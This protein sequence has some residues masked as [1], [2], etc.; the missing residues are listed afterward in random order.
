MTARVEKL[1]P[2][3]ECLATGDNQKDQAH[4]DIEDADLLVI[5]RRRPVVEHSRPWHRA[6]YRIM[7]DNGHT[8]FPYSALNEAF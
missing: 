6:Q 3:Q 7:F 4:Q 5:Y 1:P 2:H 8:W